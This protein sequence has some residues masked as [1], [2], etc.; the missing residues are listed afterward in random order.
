MAD[1][2][3]EGTPSI[4]HVI[5]VQRLQGAPVEVRVKEGRDHWYH[6]LMLEAGY[7][8]EPEHMDAEDMLYILYTSGT[9]G[10]PK[11]IVHTTGGYLVGTYCD[12]EV[13]VRSEGRRCVLVHRGHRLGHRSQLCRLWAARKR[14]DRCDV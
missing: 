7:H 1:E 4:K 9:T 14:C 12:H 10:K 13:G 6:R 11:G 5:I 8:C 3:L 2:A